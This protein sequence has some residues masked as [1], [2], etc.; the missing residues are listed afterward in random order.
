MTDRGPG[1]RSGP[2][3]L[4]LAVFALLA[5]LALGAFPLT[6]LAAA[7][8]DAGPDFSQVTTKAAARKLVREGRLVEVTLFPAELGGPD[9]DPL[10]LAYVTPEAA[11]ARET[12]I[13]A[14]ARSVEEGKVDQMTVSPEY[15]GDSIVPSRITFVARHSERE[16]GF[17]LA[18]EVW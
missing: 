18:V 7:R 17:E 10:N 12:A 13:E 15:R 6:P 4:P 14:L 16:G 11:A 9:D 1:T 5:L 8:D 2:H 3:R